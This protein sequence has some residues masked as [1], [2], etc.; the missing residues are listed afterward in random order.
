M[1]RGRVDFSSPEMAGSK[2][3]PTICIN[4]QE[5][6]YGHKTAKRLLSLFRPMEFSI[7]FDTD[8]MVHHIY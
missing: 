2:N 6:N 7:K 3:V 5:L 8:R 1:M 4:T